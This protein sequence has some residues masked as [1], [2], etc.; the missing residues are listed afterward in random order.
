MASVGVLGVGWIKGRAASGR[1]KDETHRILAAERRGEACR[2]P[3][4]RSSTVVEI[5]PQSFRIGGL[6]RHFR[7]RDPVPST[8]RSERLFANIVR[9]RDAQRRL[10]DDEGLGLVLADLERELGPTVSRNLAAKLLGI[11]HTGLQRWIQAGDV[12]L[13]ADP[14]GKVG[15]P[16]GALLRLYDALREQ[17][18][19]GEQRLH[20]LEPLMLHGRNNADRLDSLRLLHDLAEG[21]DDEGGHG[22]ATRRARGYHAALARRLRKADV[23][24]ARRQLRRWQTDNRIDPRYAKE[25][26]E[27]LSRPVSEIKRV[28]VDDSAWADD[29]RQNSPL[30]GLL[31]EAERRRILARVR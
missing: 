7:Y 5:R 22:R 24:E 26:E 11:S 6:F 16:V 12:A 31:S 1:R 14:T 20:V 13:V 2:P 8:E 28:L 21:G 25:W 18:Q 30:A 3:C 10:P 19:L 17:R 4:I 27:V 23:Q 29:L 15:V 9:V